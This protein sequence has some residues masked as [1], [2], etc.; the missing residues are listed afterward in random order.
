M[1]QE[2]GNKIIAQFMGAELKKVDYNGTGNLTDE[3]IFK[4]HPSKLINGTG[5]TFSSL[6]DLRYQESFD[7]LMP[8]VE[9]IEALTMSYAGDEIKY[10]SVLV[11]RKY[12]LIQG[13]TNVRQPG[14]YYQT[15]YGFT[16]NSKIEAVWLAVTEFIQWYNNNQ[17]T[18]S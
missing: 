8:V 5:R 13:H 10:F 3:I 7:W 9:K 17:T 15:P 1:T 4:E 12:V 14:V 18:Q 2:Q 6:I 16:P 11:E